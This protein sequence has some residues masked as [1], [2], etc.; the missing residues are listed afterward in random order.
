M[1]TPPGPPSPP[2]KRRPRYPGTHP[3]RFEERYKELDAEK[4]PDIVPHVLA[5]GR[6]PAGQH[7]PILVEEVLE[8]LAPV[9]GERAVDCTLGY[10]GHAERIL[11]RLMPGGSLIGL[12]ADP[13]ALPRT[14]AR[15]R[16]LGHDEHAFVARRSNFAGLLSVLGEAGWTGGADVILADL[17]VSSM[18]LDDPSR[19]FTFGA[20]GPLDMRM[21]PSRGLSAA[22]W[23][24]R[25]GPARL[26]EVLSKNADEPHAERIAEALGRVRGRIATTQALADLVRS[27]L[28]HDVSADEAEHSVRRVFQAL[29]IEVNDEFGALDA[30]LRALPLGLRPGGRVAVLSFHSGE[31]RRVKQAFRAGER[32]GVYAAIADDVIRASSQERHDNPRS[33]PAKLRWAKRRGG[34]QGDDGRGVG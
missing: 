9:A 25:Q 28:A 11:H 26:T 32:A 7:V 4:Y 18:Q 21:N 19:G 10:G 17:G 22:E 29:R 34:T 20:E 16:K 27:A 31:D 6:T 8:V 24:E 13:L 5:K 1:T 2:H 33:R 3:R 23:L 30:L 12:D 14:E 15:L